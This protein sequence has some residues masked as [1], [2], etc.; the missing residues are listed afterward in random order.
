MPFAFWKPTAPSMFW[1]RLC[2]SASPWS[3]RSMCT[4]LHLPSPRSV[5]WKTPRRNPVVRVRLSWPTQ[6]M[7]RF[8]WV[9]HRPSWWIL[10][11]KPKLSGSLDRRFCPFSP[12]ARLPWHPARSTTPIFLLNN[13][14]RRKASARR[15]KRRLR[16]PIRDLRGSGITR[17]WK[18]VVSK[19]RPCQAI[20]LPCVLKR[21]PEI[22]PWMKC[23]P[24][25]AKAVK[26][27]L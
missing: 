8:P 18:G 4:N 22:T 3:G 2:T 16:W 15:L 14:L 21:F 10:S 7:Q 13:S 24:R 1:H 5:C 11:D 17:I 27:I 6:C 19:W 26:K 20:G 12:T 25:F 23:W 9:A